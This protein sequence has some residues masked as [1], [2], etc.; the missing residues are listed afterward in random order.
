MKEIVERSSGFWIVNDTG[1]VDGPFLTEEEAQA[2]IP[3]VFYKTV[4][5]V[6]VLSQEP[7]GEPSLEQ[8]AY[9]ITDGDWSG[10]S[11][12]K[13]I[14]ELTGKQAAKALIKQGSDPEFF[15]LD[16]KGNEIDI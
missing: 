9:N 11:K 5:Q 1:P 2:K 4:I 16:E 12:I 8:L 6:E 13:S 3:R 10:A 14:K 15:Q 7:I